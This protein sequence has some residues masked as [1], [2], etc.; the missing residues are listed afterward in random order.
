MGGGAS[1]LEHSNLIGKD[2]LHTPTVPQ[3]IP[4]SETRGRIGR[5]GFLK[6]LVGAL[7]AG[8]GISR[9]TQPTDETEGMEQKIRDRDITREQVQGDTPQMISPDHLPKN[10]ATMTAIAQPTATPTEQ[11]QGP[12]TPSLWERT[13]IPPESVPTPQPK[14]DP[15]KVKSP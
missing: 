4:T 5:R 15:S 12:P 8:I 2:V 11:P 3:A 14:L 10:A 6:M 9:I 13:A 1:E 7:L